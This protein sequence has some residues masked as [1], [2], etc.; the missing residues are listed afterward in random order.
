MNVS[1]SRWSHGPC[2]ATVAWIAILHLGALAAPFFFTWKGLAL[3]VGLVWI[4]GGIGICLG[5][6]RLFSHHGFVVPR[7]LRWLIAWLGGMAGEGPVIRWV[8]K[9]RLHHARSDSEGDP[10]SPRDGFWWSHMIWL[11][12]RETRET[13]RALYQRW[14]PDLLRDP[15]LRF[16]DVTFIVWHLAFGFALFM[17]GYLVW[18]LR[19]ALSLVVWGVFFRIVFVLHGTWFVN[20]ATHIWGYRNYETDDRSRNLWWVALITFGEGW[21]NNHH[22]HPR[23][24]RH[25]HRWWELDVTYGTIWL[26][27]K[28]GLARKVV[29]RPHRRRLGVLQEG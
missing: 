9:H 26:L 25:G 18:D 24:A 27:E 12:P 7:P 17:L 28:L 22:A 8:A 23:T 11:F 4:T 3:M 29:H 13:T 19:T 15:V 10:H 5:Y 14:A 20:S 1:T 2:W 16:I 21:H 6:H